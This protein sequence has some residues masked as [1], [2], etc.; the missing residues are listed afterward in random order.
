ITA[1]RII[2]CFMTIPEASRLVLTAGAMAKSGELFVLDMGRPVK[3]YDLAVNMIKLSGL[4]PG[5]DVEIKEIGLRPGEK[6]YEELLIKTESL[7]KTE[8]KKIFIEHD[9]PLTR[10]EVDEKLNFLIGEVTSGGNIREA[11]RKAVPTFR[12]PDELNRDADSADE[13]HEA[14]KEAVTL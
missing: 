8:N 12:D 6:L 14:E 5:R 7:T 11:M 4:E 13:M 1:K 3:I 2:R 9:S 10:E